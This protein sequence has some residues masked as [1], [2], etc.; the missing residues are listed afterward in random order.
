MI[1]T[2]HP[3]PEDL[4]AFLRGRLGAPEDRP[5]RLAIFDHLIGGCPLCR[6]DAAELAL[7]IFHPERAADEEPPPG[8]VVSLP[9]QRT[10]RK[11]LRLAGQM[12]AARA[13]AEREMEGLCQPRYPCSSALRWARAEIALEEARRLRHDDPGLTLAMASIAWGHADQ[14]LPEDHPPQEIAR[15]HYEIWA[16]I[17]NAHRIGGDLA[18]TERSLRRCAA[19]G[20]KGNVGLLETAQAAEVAALFLKDSRAYSEA[21]ELFERACFA[22]LRLGEKHF[23]GR[24]L[25]YRGLVAGR[26]QDF[27]TAVGYFQE[28][29]ALLSTD[30]DPELLLAA[31][32]NLIYYLSELGYPDQAT[33]LVKKA[34]PLYAGLGGAI[35]LIKLRW[36]E[37]KIEAARG[38]LARGEELLREARGEFAAQ[39][40]PYQGAL[41][42]LDLAA[43][44]L[45]RGKTREIRE[46]VAEM[47]E[48]FQAL[49]IRPEAFAALRLLKEAADQERATLALLQ[50]VTAQMG[51]A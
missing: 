43:V 24:T 27:E 40:L 11:V 1:D 38:S 49:K 50:E 13:Q 42:T 22:Y 25:V 47:F 39:D 19:V 48:I 6:E 23:A 41:V 3:D 18:A 14:L 36:L 10:K 46:A 21:S 15:L 30:R 4:A 37:G 26:L 20:I 16:E 44:W 9:W 5:K 33:E 34:R 29:L 32:H 7:P 12:A 31:Y 28:G 8:N 35:D 17:A 2:P 45:L 51:Q